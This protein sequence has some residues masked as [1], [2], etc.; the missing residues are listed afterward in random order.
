MEVHFA[1]IAAFS[2]SLLL[3]LGINQVL[4]EYKVSVS[5]KLGSR[6]K[7]EV[8][9]VTFSRP[10]RPTCHSNSLLT[11]NFPLELIDVDSVP[12]HSGTLLT[13]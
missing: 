9:T 11:E 8:S 2:S 13:P 1:L 7:D 6:R 4:K 3:V 5:I 12:P 10:H